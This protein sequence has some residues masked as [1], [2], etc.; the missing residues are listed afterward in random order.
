MI[1]KALKNDAKT[2]MTEIERGYPQEW[3]NTGW[4]GLKKRE[5]TV[6]GGE[7]ARSHSHGV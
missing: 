3:Q 4:Q 1:P 6:K 2:C 7:S 5:I